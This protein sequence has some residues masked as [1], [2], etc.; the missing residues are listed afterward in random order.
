MHAPRPEA[1]A[2]TLAGAVT[3]GAFEA[4]VLHVLAER[5]IPIRRIMAVSSGALNGTA[6]AAGIRA[7]REKAAAKEL[8]TLW[9]EQAGFCNVIS[10]NVIDI[11][12]R[13]GLSDQDKLLA[14]LRGHVLPSHIP[15]PASIDLDII[16][17]PLSGILT[18]SDSR[19]WTTYTKVLSFQ[20]EHF[21]RA[22]GLEQV[23]RATTASAAF[24]LLFAPVDLPGLGPCVDGGMVNN[25]P[26]RLAQLEGL[27]PAL[28]TILVVSPL[29]V[30]EPRDHMYQGR[31]LASHVIDMLFA[32]RLHHDVR[33]A[34]ETTTLQII[35]IRPL[36]PLPGGA[37]SGLFS[38]WARRQYVEI[39]VERA[40]QVLDQ[41]GWR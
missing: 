16:V 36:T 31:R 33:Q 10:I 25:A 35:P 18:S 20:G 34:V 30:F 5:E 4:G 7:R 1:I 38:S 12:R 40:N 11:L 27:G 23:F 39:G 2:L 19:P 24:P 15:D 22:E 13:V 6:Y 3:R 17:A 9:E 29:P 32:E 8:I 21:D 37:F 26:I 41:I 28:N 14:L